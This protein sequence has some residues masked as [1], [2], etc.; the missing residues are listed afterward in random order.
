VGSK[1][2]LGGV[3]VGSVTLVNP[4]VEG[5]T[6]TSSIDVT[7]EIDNQYKLYSNAD[8]HTQVGL[9]GTGAW[10]EITSVGNG[11][12]ATSET[13]LIGVSDTLIGQFVGLDAEVDI[14]KTL[15]SLR[16]ISEVISEEKGALN[17]LIG[18][19]EAQSIRDSID[20]A[21]SALKSIDSIVSSTETAWP[22]WQESVSTILT[23]SRDLPSK[24]SDTLSD[25]KSAV[26]DVRKNVLPNVEHAMS[27]LKESMKSLE[28]ISKTYQKRAPSWSSKISNIVNNVESITERAKGLIEEIAGSPWKL[29]YR[30]KDKDIIYEQLNNA[31]WQ[32]RAVLSELRQTASE[33]SVASLDPDAPEDAAAIAKTLKENESVFIKAIEEIKKQMPDDFPN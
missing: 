10:L 3:V 29:I 32:L 16:I 19:E 1:V 5:E 4:R 33:L 24:M 9:L 21:N 15:E 6:P 20:S 18:F 17:L 11:V 30:P 25:V 23:D 14:S 26:Q 31:S 8:I 28:S 12:L 7:F 22:N 27:S 13:E 2:R